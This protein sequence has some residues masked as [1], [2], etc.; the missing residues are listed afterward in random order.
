MFTAAYPHSL[1]GLPYISYG[2]AAILQLLTL[3]PPLAHVLPPRILRRGAFS[4]VARMAAAIAA[5]PCSAFSCR[6]RMYHCHRVPLRLPTN[7]H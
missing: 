7:P 2:T 6:A 4:A 5:N 1:P 3:M